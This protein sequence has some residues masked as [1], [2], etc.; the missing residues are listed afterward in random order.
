M[1]YSF[2]FFFIHSYVAQ[3]NVLY[4]I[5][6]HTLLEENFNQMES[7]YNTCTLGSA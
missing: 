3:F 7:S 1:F 4:N 6:S 2:K 5:F